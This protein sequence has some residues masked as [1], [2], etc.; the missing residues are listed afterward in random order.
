[1]EEPPTVENFRN[2]I[3]HLGLSPEQIAELIE[4]LKS[5]QITP[6]KGT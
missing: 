3:L 4:L 2:Q 1:M 6:Q 5:V